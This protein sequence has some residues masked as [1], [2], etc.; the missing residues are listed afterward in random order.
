MSNKN[1]N[2]DGLIY[3]TNKDLNVGNHDEEIETLAP[4][5]QQLKV[6]LESKNR[7]GKTVTVIK[8]FIGSEDAMN[9]LCKILKNKCGTGGS[10]KDGEILVQGDHREKIISLLLDQGYKAKKAGG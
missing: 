3:S 7:G 1:K 5:Q 8:S 9:D 10:V 6:W 2:R 4:E